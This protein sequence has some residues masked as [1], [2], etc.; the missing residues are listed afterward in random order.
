M[1]IGDTFPQ[2]E[3]EN[4]LGKLVNSKELKGNTFVLFAYPRASTP[5][6]TKEVCSV[7]D[8]FEELKSRN[9]RPF[10]ISNDKPEKNRKFAEKHN[11]Q[12]ELL[13]DV[14]SK[15]LESIGAYGEKKIYGRVSK[16]TFRYTFI[17]DG[18]SIVRKIFK[19]VKTDVHGQ[20]IL[21][22]IDELNL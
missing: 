13:S 1:D 10:G 4:H 21:D 19:K 14:D 17:V 12:Y 16:G 15:L 5:G 9:V 3:L 6:C 11:L 22:A 2:F 20:E 18:N 7:R 8:H